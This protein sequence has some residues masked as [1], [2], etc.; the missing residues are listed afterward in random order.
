[1]P[2]LADPS[3]APDTYPISTIDDALLSRWLQPTN[4]THIERIAVERIEDR[5][6]LKPDLAT[7]TAL[8]VSVAT[9]GVL[10]PLLLR[11]H[12]EG[13]LQVVS[14]AR[15]LEAARQEGLEYVPAIVRVM[16]DEKA[17]I[18]ALWSILEHLIITPGHADLLRR[19]L[20]TEGLN[21]VESAAL[22]AAAVERAS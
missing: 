7:L 6:E 16:P 15:R 12:P 5:L 14:G 3:A 21:H 18:I 19:I 17:R 9:S 11:H 8:R 2:E 22:V 10:A 1:M 13:S 20:V 4:E